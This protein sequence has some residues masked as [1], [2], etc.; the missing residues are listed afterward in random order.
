M[1]SAEY[2]HLSPKQLVPRL[3]TTRIVHWS[4]TAHPTASW[5]AQQFRMIASGDEAHRFVIH[6]CDTIYSQDVDA[7]SRQRRSSVV[8]ITNAG[9]SDGPLSGGR[10]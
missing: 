10:L 9:L 8:Y 6:D 7:D 5:T 1:T 2:S 4:V 3:G